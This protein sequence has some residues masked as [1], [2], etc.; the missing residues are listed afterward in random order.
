MRKIVIQTSQKDTQNVTVAIKDNGPGIDEQNIDH[1]FEP[2]Y[3]T[4]KE[5]LGM[6]LAISKSIVEAHKGSLWAENNSERGVTFYF[7]I[8]VFKGSL[9]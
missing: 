2:F 6:G 4:K 1:L 3:S 8:Q 5:G 9:A 7:T